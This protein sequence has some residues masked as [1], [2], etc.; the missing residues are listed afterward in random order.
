MP[1]DEWVEVT[2]L[3]DPEPRF[4]L[5]AS[6]QAKA[7]AQARARFLAGASDAE[8]FEAELDWIIRG[9]VRLPD[10]REVFRDEARG[11]GEPVALPGGGIGWY[12]GE[13]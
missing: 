10:G 12:G 13:P 2:V 9:R 6:G 1:D 7:I 4:I 5:S 8:G 11:I 3:G